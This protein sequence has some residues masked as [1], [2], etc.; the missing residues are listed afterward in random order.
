MYKVSSGTFNI[1]SWQ[2]DFQTFASRK[3]AFRYSFRDSQKLRTRKHGHIQYKYYARYARDLTMAAAGH[4]YG[5]NVDRGY[6][7]SDG[8]VKVKER[9]EYEYRLGVQSSPQKTAHLS[10]DK[11]CSWIMLANN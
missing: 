4:A 11:I 7:A 3:A 2:P 9:R 1:T 6:L 5:I 10:Q 8:C